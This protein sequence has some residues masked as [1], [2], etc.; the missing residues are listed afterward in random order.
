MIA[1]AAWAVVDGV[2]LP[3]IGWST[4]WAAFIFVGILF[5]R[6]KILTEKDHLERMAIL[7]TAHEAAIG[8]KDREIDR[9]DHDRQEWRTESRIKDAQMAEK[10]AQLAEQAKQLAAV[11]E[12]GRTLDSVLTAIRP[13]STG[14]AS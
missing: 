8:A 9:N 11:A 7:T 5:A 12:I 4:G 6:G 1:L 2:G 14:G 10:D 13:E 3:A